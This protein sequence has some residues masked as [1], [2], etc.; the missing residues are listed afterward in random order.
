MPDRPL[1]TIGLPAYDA[2]S[3][4]PAALASIRGQTFE[5]WELLVVDDGS[6]DG[7]GELLTELER[8]DERIHAFVDGRHL[9]V[10][11]RANQLIQIARGRLL[12]RMDADDVAYPDR[13]ERQVAFLDEHPEVDLV[14]SS[15]LV[16]GEGGVARGKRPAPAAHDE[17]CAHLRT[18][19]FP[20]FHPTWTGRADWFRR[21][22]Y[23]PKA[24][25]CEDQDLLLRAHAASTFANLPEV[26]LG[27]REERV[28][29]RPV[30]TGRVN[31]A[32]AVWRERGRESRATALAVAASQVAKGV[33][34]LAASP[35]R[36]DRGL[37]RQ[38]AGPVAEAEIQEWERVWAEVQQAASR[39]PA[40]AGGREP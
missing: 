40:P 18:R 38:R 26:L 13:L 31:W 29:L 9:G 6:T 7:T 35:L 8:T 4:L 28:R 25:R 10:S 39:Q 33:L 1:V 11:A 14:G 5:D 12:A 21:Y 36:A 30:L 32:R 24:V 17:I 20:L 2:V 15:M 23:R 3:T 16:F 22:L 34:D 37:L 19:F 27:Y